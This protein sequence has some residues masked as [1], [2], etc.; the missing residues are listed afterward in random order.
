MMFV[1]LPLPALRMHFAC[2]LRP[3]YAKGSQR[4][5]ADRGADFSGEKKDLL[6]YPSRRI[7]MTGN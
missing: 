7:T 4:A 5:R 6:A 3:K 1:P 2:T